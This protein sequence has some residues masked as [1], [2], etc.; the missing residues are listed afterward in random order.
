MRIFMP[1]IDYLKLKNRTRHRVYR[2]M[3]KTVQKSK[4][5]KLAELATEN[6]ELR[7]E[8][9]RRHAQIAEIKE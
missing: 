3:A 7:Q 5:E 4:S 1:R 9:T 8:L 2:K 6:E